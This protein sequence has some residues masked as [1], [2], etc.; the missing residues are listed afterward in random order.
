MEKIETFLN[1]KIKSNNNK[2]ERFAKIKMLMIIYEFIKI[3]T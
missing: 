2:R 3:A 1:I